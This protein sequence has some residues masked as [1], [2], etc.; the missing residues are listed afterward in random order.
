MCW[1]LAEVTVG[2]DEK[3]GH[4]PGEETSLKRRVSATA[5]LLELENARKRG[6]YQYRPCSSEFS[7]RQ[8]PGRFLP[9]LTSL[10]PFRLYRIDLARGLWL[11]KMIS[12]FSRL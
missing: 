4:D 11:A 2:L 10:C 7:A 1:I 8:F 9:S 5:Q 12:Y 6:W 3:S